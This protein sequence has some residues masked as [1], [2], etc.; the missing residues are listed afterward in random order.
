[1]SK[2]T[3]KFLTKVRQRFESRFDLSLD[4]EQIQGLINQLPDFIQDDVKS[5]D[6]DALEILLATVSRRLVNMNPPLP[7]DSEEQVEKFKFLLSQKKESLYKQLEGKKSQLMP[8]HFLSP[9]E[10]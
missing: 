9:D 5:Q 3:I 6:E 7:T 4:L 10:L 1:M 8:P 2:Y